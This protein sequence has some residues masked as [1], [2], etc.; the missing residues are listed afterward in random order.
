MQEPLG[1]SSSDTL[2]LGESTMNPAAFS[3]N[4]RSFAGFAG[5]EY[6]CNHH[7]HKAQVSQN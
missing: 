5:W 4:D 6:S 1:L 7:L 2:L 3:I